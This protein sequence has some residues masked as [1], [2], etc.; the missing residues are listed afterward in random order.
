MAVTLLA[1]LRPSPGHGR[2][3]RPRTGL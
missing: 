3:G 2:A 1:R